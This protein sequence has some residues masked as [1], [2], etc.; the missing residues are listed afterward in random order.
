MKKPTVMH[1]I[2][3]FLDGSKDEQ[4]HV[5]EESCYEDGM[6]ILTAIDQEKG[7]ITFKQSSTG[8]EIL[9]YSK[10]SILTISLDNEHKGNARLSVFKNKNEELAGKFLVKN[11]D[12][13]ITPEVILINYDL[14]DETGENL[15]IQAQIDIN[16]GKD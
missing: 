8:L 12:Y 4:N 6:I 3:T 7:S 13:K 1:T 16:R 10:N 14:Y 5:Y 15:V 9:E 11:S 2:H